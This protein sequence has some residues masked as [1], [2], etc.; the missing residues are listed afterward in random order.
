MNTSYPI[1]VNP[2]VHVGRS[3]LVY[4]PPSGKTVVLF[5]NVS[6]GWSNGGYKLAVVVMDGNT[7]GPV[8]TSDYRVCQLMPLA[9]YGA[10]QPSGYPYSDSGFRCAYNPV[11]GTIV[12]AGSSTQVDS[13]DPEPFHLNI[14]TVSIALD[15]TPS[16]AFNQH[17]SLTTGVAAYLWDIAFSNAGKLVL[18]YARWYGEVGVWS[19]VGTHTGGVV[20]FSTPVKHSTESVLDYLWLDH[21][22]LTDKFFLLYDSGGARVRLGTAGATALSVT[23]LLTNPIVIASTYPSPYLPGDGRVYVRNYRGTFLGD[24]IVW[25]TILS[26]ATAGLVHDPQSGYLFSLYDSWGGFLVNQ[27][28]SVNP[29][30]VDLFNE[31]EFVDNNLKLTD[32]VLAAGGIISLLY[33]YYRYVF[34]GDYSAIVPQKIHVVNISLADPP[35]VYFWTNN[36][37][38]VERE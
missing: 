19:M 22:T 35:Y 4:H 28:L 20:S 26:A 38:Q 9:S 14:I 16:F 34:G 23:A 12:A 8:V 3:H 2:G 27:D 17:L 32:S 5:E 21:D 7:P 36:T 37:L 33:P 6:E 29:A 10:V 24:S 18:S 1:H 15:G 25:D 31:A 11:N 13:P 30:Y